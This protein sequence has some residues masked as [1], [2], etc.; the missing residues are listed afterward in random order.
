MINQEGQIK[1]MD[2][3]IAKT[4]DTSS[5]EYTQTGTG[6]QMGTPMYMSPEQI[7]ESKAVTTQSDIYSLGIVL[8]QMVTGQKPYDTKTLSTFQLQNKIVNEPLEYTHTK[9]D[10]IIRKATAKEITL[11]YYSAAGF[12]KGLEGDSAKNTQEVESTI[13]ENDPNRHT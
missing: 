12:K 4:T 9:W 5:A 1:L 2:F 10:A 8:W 13:I 6:V 7:T 11:R 3:G